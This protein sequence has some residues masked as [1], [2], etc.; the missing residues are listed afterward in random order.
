MNAVTRILIVDDHDTVREGLRLLLAE[1]PALE[2]VGEAASGEEA[3]SLASA[4][5][6]EVILMDVALPGIDGLEAIRRI[7]ASGARPRI[8]VLTSFANG[9]LLDEAR[10][11]GA[12]GYLFKNVLKEK[13]LQA[14]RAVAEGRDSFPPNDRFVDR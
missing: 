2:V 8:L 7:R 1:E 13:L 5:T 3:I 11:A 12:A 6:P 9:M 10:S 14:I 4:L